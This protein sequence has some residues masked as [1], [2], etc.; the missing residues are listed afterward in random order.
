MTLVNRDCLSVMEDAAGRL[1][2][3][4]VSSDA[5]RESFR[6]D[7]ME[8]D[9]FEAEPRTIFTDDL[10]ASQMW[11]AAS[12]RHFLCE[13]LGTVL[14]QEGASFRRAKLDATQLFGI[15]GLAEDAVYTV[16]AEGRCFRFDGKAWTPMHVPGGPALSAVHGRSQE[17]VAVVG[18][19][20]LLARWDGS[21]WR[22]IELP[23]K[24]RLRAVH[25]MPDG[26][27]Y[28]AGFDG[29][30][31]RLS[32]GELTMIEGTRDG[33]YAIQPFKGALYVGSAEGGI[34]TVGD[35]GLSSVKPKARGYFMHANEHHL[36]TCGVTQMA[37]F[38][39]TKWRART[40]A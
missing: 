6:T 17:D 15:W 19:D 5:D 14:W 25:V 8:Y 22:V 31:V 9:G 20:G 2:A 23:V 39:G 3:L 12:G 4:V 11:K 7:V 34:F 10:W 24:A 33:L 1:S 30:F 29:V 26:T 37:Q 35:A 38:D 21:D 16:G 32:G 40:F 36:S 18:D 13:V 27:L 28:A